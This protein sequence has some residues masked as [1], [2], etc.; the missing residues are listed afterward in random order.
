M[1][2][3]LYLTNLITIISYLY[4][5]ALRRLNQPLQQGI[6]HAGVP[7]E[8]LF[9]LNVAADTSFRAQLG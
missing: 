7:R 9:W 6:F 8:S 5:W 4:V 1:I 3:L 2:E